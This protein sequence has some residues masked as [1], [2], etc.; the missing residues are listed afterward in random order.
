MFGRNRKTKVFG[1][2]GVRGAELPG[3]GHEPPN[4]RTP[5]PPNA[6]QTGSVSPKAVQRRA[7]RR[8]VAELVRRA[9]RLSPILAKLYPDARVML[10]FE[11]PLHL[12]VATILAAQCTDERVNQVTPALFRRY[13]TAEGFARADPA[14]LEEMIRSTGF[15]RSKA[16]SVI[17]CCRQIAERH[18]GHVPRTME[19]LTALPGVGRKT[20]NVVLWNAFRVPGL[21]VDTHVGRVVNRIGLAA[22]DDPDTIEAQVCELFPRERWGIVTHLV[23]FHGRK[24]CFARKPNC[25]AC[26]IRNLCDYPDKTPSLTATKPSRMAAR[27]R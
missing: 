27:R 14:A 19:E 13:R 9:R 16:R 15:F 26:A 24:T 17:A 20:A 23:G 10:D 2:S 25:P 21:A 18:G 7:K 5:E 11:T 3:S 1:S 12:L 6:F 4:A 8:D 22:S